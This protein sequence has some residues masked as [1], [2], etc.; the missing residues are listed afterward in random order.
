MHNVTFPEGVME[1]DLVMDEEG[2][3]FEV[4][5]L[6]E[7]DEMDHEEGLEERRKRRKKKLT[8]YRMQKQKGGG[9]KKVRF[10]RTA[11]DIRDA[12]RSYRKNRA[13]NRIRSKQYRRRKGK[14]RL[15][16]QRKRLQRGRRA[17][18]MREM[19]HHEMMESIRDINVAILQMQESINLAL[20][21]GLMD[22]V[23]T[24]PA[25]GFD[26]DIL[27]PEMDY[28]SALSTNAM[29]ANN[30]AMMGGAASLGIQLESLEEFAEAIA[31]DAEAYEEGEMSES[32]A[33]DCVRYSSAI[34]SQ[35]I[36]AIEDPF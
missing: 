34:L 30:L 14:A 1:G 8:G 36:E 9:Y 11:K 31:E 7:S 32:E 10:R 35:V 19:K 18:G 21:E 3:Y 28:G 4:V 20:E 33:L 12:E 22:Q 16:L 17:A 6:G 5:S 15:G 23:E 24:D 2:N 27:Q 29:I 25:G 26:I 13:K